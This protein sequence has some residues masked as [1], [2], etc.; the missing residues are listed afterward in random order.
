MDVIAD[1]GL[2]ERA[3]LTSAH[4]AGR[5][6]ALRHPCIAE[7]RANGL[8]FAVELTADGS[9]TG[10]PAGAFAAEVVQG[11]LERGVLM[12]LIGTGRNILKIRPPMP[13]G[14]EEADLLADRLQA[15]LDAAPDP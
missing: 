13:F 7:T 6:A 3:A 10:A 8:F 4:L 2:V 15:A 9:P 11:M 5:L 12:N 1:E 14:P